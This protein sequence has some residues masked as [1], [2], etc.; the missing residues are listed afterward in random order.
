VAELQDLWA[1]LQARRG[2]LAGLR[3]D[4]VTAQA[5]LMRRRRE[6][7]RAAQ[8]AD[9]RDENALTAMDSAVAEAQARVEELRANIARS[10][11]GI[12]QAL[13]DLEALTDPRHAIVALDKDVPLLLMPVRIETRFKDGELWVRFYPDQWAADGFQP[14]LSETEI[15]GA[16]RFWAALFRAGGD[17]GRRRSAWRG[18]VAGHGSG[19]AGWIISQFAPLNPGDEPVRA[20]DD[21][22]IL[23][24]A[25]DLTLSAP[26]QEAAATYWEQLWRAG[27]RDGSL[28][29]A[30]RAAVGD[31]VA[32]GVLAH[33][34]MFQ[35]ER[36]EG[37]DPA[38]VPVTVA[39]CRLPAI[40]EG[41]LTTT[42]WTTAAQAHVLPDRFALLGFRAGA[43]VLDVLGE[44]IPP[45]LAVGPDPNAGPSEQFRIEDGDLV[46]PDDLRW[47]TDFDEAVRVGMGLR[48]PLGQADQGGFDR[49]F[50]IGVRAAATPAEDQA[51]L[52]TLLAHHRRTRLGISLLAQ[53]T[54]TNNTENL[55][56]GLDRL[57]DPDA[58]YDAYLGAAPGLSDR[59]DWN[60]KQDG[61]WL[62]EVLGIDPAV[63][64]GVSGADGSD[65][66]EAR[67]MNTAL[68]PATLGYFLESM[69]HPLFGDATIE[70]VRHFFL[71]YVSGR[72][73][74]P[75]LRIGR[76]PYGILPIT[77]LGRLNAGGSA[78]PG[79]A[80]APDHAVL[81]ALGEMLARGTANLQKLVDGVPHVFGGGDPHQTLLD[82]LGLHP[83]SVEFHHR[84]A[85]SLQDVFNRFAMDNLGADFFSAWQAFGSL[86]AG[87]NLL[88][89]LGY[90]GKETPDILGKLFHGA[91]H[92]LH[93]P[94]VD[95]RPL[96]ETDP[97]RAYCD[98][99]RNYLQWLV[100]TGSKSLQEL[101]LE[102]GFSKDAEPDALLYLLARHALL[103]SWWDAGVRL[104]LE[105]GL[106][107]DKAFQLARL[108]PA[109]VHVSGSGPTES[110]WLPLYDTAA[111]ITGDDR[112]LLHEIMPELLGKDAARHLG[113]V[114]A[115][116]HAL[117]ELP[118]ARLE[119]LLAEHLDSCSHR[120]DAWRL[121]L[122]TRRLLDLR[123]V[124]SP[125]SGAPPKPAR[126]IH[127]G[128]F[129][130][131]EAVHPEKH[132]LEPVVLPEA[133]E[134]VF[135]RPQDAPL[136]ADRSNGGF[137]HAPSLNHAATAAI[138]RSGFLANATPA[139][140]DTMALNISSERMRLAVSVL[141]GLRNGQSLSALLG[142]RFERGL[143]DRHALA[144]VD[145]LIH[146]LRLAF[147][148][149]GDRDGRLPL[150]GL[151]LARRALEPGHR[152][153]P[154]GLPGLPFV[155]SDKQSAVDLE[156][157]RL[158][159]VHDAVADLV[160]AEGV[161]Q[162]VL[163]NVDRV[164][165]TLD[166]VGRGSFPTEP[167]VLETPRQGV[168]LTHRFAVHL[169]TG[170]DHRVSPVAGVPMTPRATAE[171]AVNEL[172]AALLP[173]PA[174]V[175]VPVSWTEPDGTVRRR[176]VSQQQL[177]LQP[178]DLLWLV[179]L[180]S[181]AA[182]G[183][184]DERIVWHV[185][186]DEGLRPDQAVSVHLTE[187]VP[188]QAT[189]FEIAPL[190]GH[191]RSLVTKA[192]PVRPS[193]AVRAGDAVSSLD[194]AVHADRARPAAV[195]AALAAREADLVALQTD[196][197]AV[198]D[199]PALLTQMDDL[200]VRAVGAFLD[201]GR[202][203]LVACGWGDLG[204]R[205][206]AAFAAVGAAA[207]AAADRWQVRLERAAGFL[208]QDDNLPATATDD[209]RIRVLL[210]ADGE[211]SAAVTTPVPTDAGAYRTAIE[212]QR[213]LFA[214]KLAAA[215][216]VPSA[217]SLHEALAALGALLPVDAFDA[218]GV[219]VAGPSGMVTDLGHY[220]GG[221]VAT[222]LAGVRARL[223]AGSALLTAADD[224]EPGAARVEALT[225]AVTALLGS[226][227]LF[228]PEFDLSPAQG[229]EWDAAM[230]WSRTGGLLA[231]L[232]GRDFPVD[233]WLHGVARVREKLH[234]WEQAALLA[235]A[236]GSPEPEL[237]PVQLP[238]AAEPWLALEY[239][240]T[241]TPTAER[242]LYTAHYPAA[243]DPAGPQAGLLVDE[244]VE[245]LPGENVDTGVVFNY[246]AP[247]AEAPQSMLLVTPPDPGAGWDWAD[248]VQA[249]H[250]ALD[251]ARLRAVEPDA[252]ATTPYAAFLPATVSEATVTGLGIS[253]N[254][255]LNNKLFAYLK[256]DHG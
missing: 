183:E 167:A 7:A 196:L 182:L 74:V 136:A 225:R 22:V 200:L 160:L 236:L 174:G 61:Q 87:R 114:L 127:L 239:P 171:P 107:D 119:R 21:E 222:V 129:G 90:Q 156:V 118:T 214:A 185:V 10:R 41:D 108:E 18:L 15:A 235:S 238:H 205:Q 177:G 187:R 56:A 106:I 91:Q 97:I 78:V 111:A 211:V 101:R 48:V 133:L 98:D 250:D 227:A 208:L 224:A 44:P 181:E 229:A 232:T 220:L 13:A 73:K 11:E 179:T 104:R 34:P 230:V 137:V 237:W 143:H 121:G 62:A 184:L 130:W 128:A 63:F 149:D 29:A 82:V 170:L 195:A 103:L 178:V 207:A 191:L 188:G 79:A 99:G 50:A 89:G 146:P 249:M 12:A 115:A 243:F 16:T 248:V 75:V 140:P 138:L 223:A 1:A 165:A 180:E 42:S 124:P 51:E 206:S 105:A 71:D 175:K 251:L 95:D 69:M 153:Y 212:Q 186:R 5:D 233:D 189:F 161:H 76:Q 215:R 94:L 3:A 45:T 14:A 168:T 120:V 166:S 25:A 17:E 190:V 204:E 72:G 145:S 54:P 116:L 246:D 67:A 96:S 68:W 194:A 100:D 102:R 24:V 192:R 38:T 126:G 202:F 31:T 117:Q 52:E 219:D 134:E 154:F 144:E 152:P 142:Y 132:D 47:M 125:S 193:D 199:D 19:R 155:T 57:D 85:E 64:A 84:Y 169:R 110:R 213:D 234:T 9:P 162:A 226:D 201:T 40:A 59:P 92:R 221:R 172:L 209:E 256:V 203:G 150:D 139:H 151:A 159:D 198:V 39:F 122:V 164:A 33:V 113:E 8:V 60:A 30:L 147:P 135:A 32:D 2:A 241:F 93:G 255:A 83:A 37:A 36:P 228:V 240:E 210:L 81:A 231:G 27:D 80:P 20:S 58:S 217:G 176:T 53:G 254:L 35:D 123:G 163:G 141:Q 86:L 253:M 131:L 245:L 66:A 112:T 109:F 88:A 157:D 49:L 26:D 216:A 4:L 6:R 247:D 148:T 28:L 43:Q 70:Q 46:V 197:A 173:A 244:W 77:A 252:L 55:P 158:L 242:V 218:A 23:V 65:Q